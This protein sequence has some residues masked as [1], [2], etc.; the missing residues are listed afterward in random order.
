MADNGAAGTIFDI[1]RYS[2]HDGPGIRTILFL[3]GCPLRCPWCSNPESLTVAPQLWQQKRKCVGCGSCLTA[4]PAGAIMPGGQGITVDWARCDSCGKCARAC[5]SGALEMIGRA[6][7]VEDAVEA[8]LRD[9]AFYKDTGG[10]TLSGGEP[11]L[12]ADFAANV[13]RG[14]KERGLHTAMETTGYADWRKIERLLP[15]TDFFLYDIKLINSEKHKAAVGV[16]NARILRNAEN[17]A[18]AGK[19]LVVRVPVVPGIND[20]AENLRATVRF[21]AAIG[22]RS[23]DLLPYHRLGEPKWERLGKPYTL[24]GTPALSN[25]CLRDVLDAIGDMHVPVT[26]GGD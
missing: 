23:V 25:A 12:Q 17:I 11:L 1:Q 21:A 6:M 26:V 8:A 15:Y 3:K 18:S 19:P 13:L 10:V 7:T 20:D 4:C 22:A 5:C 24:G 14:C 2:V 9:R 16:D